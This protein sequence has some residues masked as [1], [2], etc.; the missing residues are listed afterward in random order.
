MVG[1]PENILCSSNLMYLK[2]LIKVLIKVLNMTSCSKKSR[3]KDHIL[4][5]VVRRLFL[6][7]ISAKD[8][9]FLNETK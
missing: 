3:T 2:F 4:Y 6:I 5:S 7:I 8:Q 9:I 1:N